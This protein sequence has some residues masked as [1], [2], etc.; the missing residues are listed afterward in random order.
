MPSPDLGKGEFIQRFKEQ[1]YDPAFERIGDDIDRVAQ[2]AWE[3]YDQS[4]NAPRYR[5]AGRG[6]KHPKEEVSIEWLAASTRLK[7]AEREQKS[8]RA[9]DRV[10]L[11]NGSPR[12][13]H[14]CPGEMSKSFR[15]VEAARETLE[16][17]GCEVEVLDLSRLT[18][19]YGRNIHPCKSCVSTAMPLCHWPCSCYPN[20]AL[21]QDRDWMNDIYESWVRAHGVMIV[22]PVHW[23]QAPSVLKLMIDRLVC[24]D[25]GNADLTSTH[26]KDARVAKELELKG[27]DFPKHLAGR[28]Y[29]VLAHGDAGGA[30]QV[31]RSLADWLTDMGLEPASKNA[32]IDRYIGYLE[33]YSRNHL[34]LDR[35]QAIFEETAIAARALAGAIRLR[36]RGKLVSR[37]LGGD[38]PRAK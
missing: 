27:W 11:I 4:R 23:Y 20:Y 31:R 9:R 16:Q 15:L 19:E 17:T 28:F 34:A 12:T 3:S 6:F 8:P 13:E 35:D 14:T 2:V 7:R 37:P 33:D 22:T 30:E 10:L 26:G 18:S 1:F 5:P 25:G 36:R 32:V 24:A 38:E 21:G 29:A